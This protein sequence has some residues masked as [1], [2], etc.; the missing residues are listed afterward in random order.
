MTFTTSAEFLIAC[1]G[2]AP[3]ATT[4]VWD[5]RYKVGIDRVVVDTDRMKEP[6]IDK[7]ISYASTHNKAVASRLTSWRTLKKSPEGTTVKNL[8]HLVVALKGYIA[9]SPHK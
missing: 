1:F 8:Q 7:L 3:A 6:D 5:M 2:S 4:A 9:A